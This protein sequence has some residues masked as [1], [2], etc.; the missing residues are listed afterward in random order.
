[1][2]KESLGSAL[3]LCGGPLSR[4][5][6]KKSIKPSLRLTIY[7]TLDFGVF[8]PRESDVVLDS[9][10]SSPIKTRDQHI[11]VDVPA[12]GSLSRKTNNV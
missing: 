7:C 12:S 2:V 1:M 5:A 6:D 10:P 4:K 9:G 8:D 11:R 3:I